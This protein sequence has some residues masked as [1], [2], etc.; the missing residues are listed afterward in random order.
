MVFSLTNEVGVFTK[1]APLGDFNGI[2]EILSLN[3]ALFNLLLTIRK[4]KS[5]P[6]LNLGFFSWFALLPL[7]SHLDHLGACVSER[8]LRS[9]PFLCSFEERFLI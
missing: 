7:K 4:S 8:K 2:S 3:V 5:L 1:L 9:L 6:N